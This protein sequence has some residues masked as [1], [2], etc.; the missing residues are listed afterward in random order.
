MKRP[1]K[2]YPSYKIGSLVIDGRTGQVRRNATDLEFTYTEFE[3]LLELVRRADKVVL[4]HEFPPWHKVVEGADRR[5]PVDDVVVR[6]KQRLGEVPRIKGVWGQGYQLIANGSVV[7][8]PSP[9]SPESNRRS[10]LG[11]DRMNLHTAEGIRSS[12]RNYQKRLSIELE[13]NALVNLAMDYMNLGHTGFCQELSSKA[14]DLARPLID[15]VIY[16]FPEFSSGYALRGLS[17]LIYAYDWVGAKNDFEKALK[18]DVDDSYAHLFLAHLEVA[19]RKFES[20]LAHAR[21]AAELDWQSPMAV[22]TVPWMLVFAGRPAEAVFEAE[23]ALDDLDPFAV[24]HT[25][26]G[27]ALEAAG[28]GTDA[29]V[30]YEKSLDQ[31]FFPS[32]VAAL[33]HLR[34]KLGEKKVGLECLDILQKAVASKKMAYASGYHEALIYMGMGDKSRALACLKKAREQQCDWLM[35]LD[36]EPRWEPLRK[37]KDFARLRE[38]I[39]LAR[40][41][42]MQTE[43]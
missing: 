26:H 10:T 1:L 42:S 25:I 15:K 3:V 2:E 27:W 5:H 21:R 4:R 41:D 33:G 37:F 17:Y 30:A 43:S 24:G 35:Y 8:I 9:S 12:I 13:P 40:T 31:K 34:A 6:I 16:R 39:G 28:R 18:L 38:N 14:A 20:G 22:F 11:L 7:E 36:V 29:I 19:Q 32:T 23:R